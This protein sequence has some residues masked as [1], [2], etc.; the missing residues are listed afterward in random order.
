MPTI[1]ISNKGFAGYRCRYSIYRHFKTSPSSSTKSSLTS[2]LLMWL[3]NCTKTFGRQPWSPLPCKIIYSLFCLNISIIIYFLK[4][5]TYFD[6]FWQLKSGWHSNFSHKSS[7]NL[8]FCPLEPSC[9]L[10]YTFLYR[11]VTQYTGHLYYSE[12]DWN[13]NTAIR[14][15]EVLSKGVNEVVCVWF[16]LQERNVQAVGYLGEKINKRKK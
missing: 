16:F 14:N 1:L 4:V 10:S 11:L 2:P 12:Q 8:C 7:R 5:T 15:T 13:P 6:F 9:W 3:C